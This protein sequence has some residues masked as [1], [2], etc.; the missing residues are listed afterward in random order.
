MLQSARMRPY[1]HAF[2]SGSHQR[3]AYRVG[4]EFHAHPKKR[5]IGLLRTSGKNIARVFSLWRV[6]LFLGPVS[7]YVAR[8]KEK[9]EEK[10]M[11]T[12]DEASGV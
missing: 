1:K 11:M 12:D 2:V 9:G 10:E 5:R 3:G 4:V 7:M 6:W 8:M